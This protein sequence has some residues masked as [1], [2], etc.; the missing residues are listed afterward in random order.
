L[1]ENEGDTHAV[2]RSKPASLYFHTSEKR[3]CSG[4]TGSAVCVIDTDDDTDLDA[5]MERV[6]DG[7]HTVRFIF[8]ANALSDVISDSW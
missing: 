2:P 4:P 1:S 8:S 6:D 3:I 7:P 5:V